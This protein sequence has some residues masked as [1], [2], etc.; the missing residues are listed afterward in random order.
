MYSTE[1]QIRVRYGETDRMGY[2]YYA[3]FALFFEV[4]RTEMLRTLGYTYK[5]WEDSGILLPVRSLS[6]NYKSPA[7]YDDL[8]TIRTII[9]KLPTA[10][11]T[12]DYEV[13]NEQDELVCTGNTVLV[14]IDENS[15]RPTRP[16]DGFMDALKKNHSFI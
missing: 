5:G 4:G 3:N 8:L 1:T 13:I 2:V 7:Y 6:V 9:N 12:F 15:R 16:P 11:I 10:K 14:F